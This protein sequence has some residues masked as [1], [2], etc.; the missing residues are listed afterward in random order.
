M[1]IRSIILYSC[2]I[3]ST[4]CLVTAYIFAGYWLILPAFLAIVLF[5]IFTKNQP[6]FLSASSLL[7][8]FVI[9]AAIGITINLSL[10]LMIVACIT[11][12]VSWDLIQF[13]QSM[14]GNS[15]RRTSAS[16]ENNHLYS[17]ALAAFAGLTLALI[18]SY[19]NLQF[20]FALILF[21][22]LMA[23]GCLVGSM[24]YIRNKKHRF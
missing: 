10:I 4:L 17:L 3:I 19:I 18:S 22:V 11:A 5:W 6:V 13:N 1:T 16:L 23:M 24:Q 14:V 20:P 9:L 2:L 8:V 12:L 21:L 15:P 7:V